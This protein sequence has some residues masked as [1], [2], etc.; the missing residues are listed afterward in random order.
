MQNKQKTQPLLLDEAVNGVFPF[1][2]KRSVD[3]RETFRKMGWVP[4][5]EQKGRK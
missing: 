1:Q 5:S 3:I 4:P 2:H